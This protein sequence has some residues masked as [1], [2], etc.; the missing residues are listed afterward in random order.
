VVL[1]ERRAAVEDGL[2]V[3]VEGGDV[4]AVREGQR[5]ELA[6]RHGLLQ[7]GHAGRADHVVG[8][9]AVDQDRLGDLGQVRGGDAP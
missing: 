5:G 6:G 7:D 2:G 4:V 9:A 8:R 1:D 3:V